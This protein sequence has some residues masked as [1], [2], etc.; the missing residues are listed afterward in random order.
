MVVPGGWA[1][2]RTGLSAPPSQLISAACAAASAHD[3]RRSR[4]TEPIEGSASPRKPSVLTASRSSSDAILLVAWRCRASGSS[5]ARMPRPS[6]RTRIRPTPPRSTSMSMRLAP[7]SRLFSTISLT[8]EAGRSM[9]SPAA[10]WSTSSPE[11]MRMG[12][13][14]RSLQ[15]NA[16]PVRRGAAARLQPLGARGAGGG[17]P[18]SAGQGL[19]AL[20]LEAGAVGGILQEEAAHAARD[21]IRE[22]RLLRRA[23]QP[24]LF[25]GV[26]DVG[27]L[28]QHGGNVRRLQHHEAGVLHLGLAHLADVL[29]RAYH[30]FRGAGADA[31][32]LA[33]G[34][35]QQHRREAALV[36]EAHAAHEV[37]GIL[38]L[39][40]PACR[41]VRGTVYG[42]HVH[43]G[44]GDAAVG[45]GVGM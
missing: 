25:L 5:S 15:A 33:L 41:L 3:T 17:R 37:G 2:G 10:I 43:R 28:D 12:I 21:R 29:E 11:S 14:R 19:A 32:D 39:R 24:P 20:L 23:L 38:A 30:A 45:D 13:R 42:Q 8:T 7:A 4:A 26:G 27:G 44:A 40:Q 6:S 35:I 31:D 16:H 18:G 22:A 9:T 36:I 1:A 34:R